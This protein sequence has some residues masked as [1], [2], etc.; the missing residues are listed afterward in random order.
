MPLLDISDLSV[1]IP[2]PEGEVHAVRAVSLRIERG[3]IHGVIGESGCGK[4]MTGMATLGLAPK[5]TRIEAARFHFD[6]ADL[7]E[8]AKALRGKRI[9]MI[10]QDP[11]AALNPVLSIARQMDDVIRAHRT[12]PREARRREAAD[13]LAATG[14]PD[15]ERVLK[16]YPHQLSGGMQ[17]RVVIAQAL[18]TGAD[19]LIADE[20][21]TALD[22]SVGAQ[23]L[24]LLRKLVA[25]RGLTVLMIT[26]DMDVIAEACDR[27]TVLYAGR[28]VETGPVEAVLQ[29]PGHPYT[30]ALLAALPD[31]A[32]HG[33][34]LAAIEGSIPPPRT[35]IAGCA[36]APRC[37][38]AM[39]VCAAEPPPERARDRHT[40]LCH[41]PEDA[42]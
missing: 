9:G 2:T 25:E 24:A 40:W 1:R 13:L 41:L 32:P 20:P 23:V 5:G 36:F 28:S 15:P 35:R 31:A 14:L 7:R 3:E 19:F 11:A 12:L 18:A 33:A 21:T 27:A 42:A 4:T 26:H 37:P 6:G 8:Q 17:Q 22:V 30:R 34:R 10:A 38:K 29:K 39:P 16:S